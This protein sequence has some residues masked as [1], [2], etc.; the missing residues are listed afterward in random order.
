MTFV[1][2]YHLS[3]QEY[4]AGELSS[5]V[6]HECVAGETFAMVGASSAHNL[7]S[8]NIASQLR[9][10]LKGTPCHAYINDMKV[11]VAGDYY[12]PDVLVDCS[13]I[14]NDAYFVE[15]PILIVEVLS[16]STKTY[17]KTFKLQQYKKI[18]TLQEYVMV[19]QETALVEVVSRL[20]TTLL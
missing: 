5:S 20:A 2:K 7:I 17:D 11:R 12:Y 19:E 18:P 14:S 4:L 6:K 9:L 10:H 3:E 15:T 8:L 13:Q 1:K 16:A